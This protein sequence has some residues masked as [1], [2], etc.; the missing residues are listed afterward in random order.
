MKTS[1]FRSKRKEQLDSTRTR[2]KLT[3]S[4]LFNLPAETP[5]KLPKNDDQLRKT[6]VLRI[7]DICRSNIGVLIA[8]LV[9]F[10]GRKYQLEKEIQL[11]SAAG[12]VEHLATKLDVTSP[13]L[14]LSTSHKENL[15]LPQVKLY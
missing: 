3:K 13:L 9:C 8:F 4:V 5:N 7:L 1:Y 14:P 10:G 15:H 11:S 12:N 6:Q 2:A